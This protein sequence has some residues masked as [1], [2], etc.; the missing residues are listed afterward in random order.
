MFRVR[1]PVHDIAHDLFVLDDNPFNVDPMK[2]SEI[3]VLKTMING[4]FTYE[5]NS[6]GPEHDEKYKMYP[7]DFE[8]WP[9]T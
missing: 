8:R 1:E 6:E 9:T 4:K 5:A 7:G 2:I 3:N